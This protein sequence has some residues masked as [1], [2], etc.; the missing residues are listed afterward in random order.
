MSEYYR[1][2]LSGGNYIITI[3]EELELIDKYIKINEL[4]YRNKY[5]VV[6]NIDED[7]LE[8]YTIKL[9]LQ[10]IV[11]N[12]ILHGLVDND[13]AV[14]SITASK[15]NDDIILTVEDNGYGMSEDDIKTA[16]NTEKAQRRKGGYGIS[17]TIKRIKAY[18]GNEY[19]IK[20]KSEI[21]KGTK[22]IVRIK[23]IDREE[24]KLRFERGC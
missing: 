15:E 11:E 12:S 4:S 9:I 24:L 23:N 7:V 6:K 19:G 13:N 18:Y 16:L 1:G 2:I 20:I 14:I 22:V 17:N 5:T 3:K 10:P 8:L 21:G